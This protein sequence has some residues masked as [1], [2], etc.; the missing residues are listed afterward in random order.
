MAY[1]YKFG[2]PPCFGCNERTV[3]CHG[4]CERYLAWKKAD[5]EFKAKKRKEEGIPPLH[6][7]YE[8]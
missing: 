5:E 2:E 4:K 7:F 3:E 1:R 6:R 8:H